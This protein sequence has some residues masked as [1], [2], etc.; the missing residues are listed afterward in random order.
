[1]IAPAVV[2]AE[3]YGDVPGA[4]RPTLKF[5]VA[6]QRRTIQLGHARAAASPNVGGVGRALAE[7]RQEGRAYERTPVR[8]VPSEPGFGEVKAEMRWKTQPRRK[9]GT[10]AEGRPA[11]SARGGV[12]RR[13][14][15][16]GSASRR[17]HGN[18]VISQRAWAGQH[19]RR[20]QAASSR[21]LRVAPSGRHR[22]ACAPSGERSVAWVGDKKVAVAVSYRYYNVVWS[23]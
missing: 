22:R 20:S 16:S 6:A 18:G 23:T 8:T 15:W 4:K 14:H 11:W 21:R 12:C 10:P 5:G 13:W 19:R 17:A 9:P 3:K 2:A 7:G 1:M